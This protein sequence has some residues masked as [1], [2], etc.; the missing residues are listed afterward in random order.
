MSI[1]IRPLT[2]IISLGDQADGRVSRVPRVE[3]AADRFDR[4]D[5]IT[6]RD[7]AIAQLHAARPGRH[8]DT[9]LTA[10]EAKVAQLASARRSNR[11][12]AAELFI[13]VATVEA[14]LTRV[15]RK[16]GVRSRSGLAVALEFAKRPEKDSE[17]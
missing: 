13:T 6:W 16:L 4:L 3:L 12:I 8:N 9:T 17:L 15:Y 10:A 5:A 11:E 1:S 7:Q 2:P 14:H